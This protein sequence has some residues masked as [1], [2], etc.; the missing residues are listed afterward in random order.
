M[1]LEFKQEAHEL[2]DRL[3]E[4]A[5][6]SDLVYQIALHLAI[7]SGLADSPAL[8]AALQSELTDYEHGRL[9]SVEALVEKL[10]QRRWD[11]IS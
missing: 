4:T 2:V 3:P 1:S 5:D 7:R 8:R 10:S 11:V 9:I 6:W